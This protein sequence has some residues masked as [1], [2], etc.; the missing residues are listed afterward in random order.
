MTEPTREQ[1]IQGLRELADF[2]TANP[3]VPFTDH[4]FHQ[5]IETRE[6]WDALNETADMTSLKTDDWLVL[7]KLFTGGIRLDVNVERPR[8]ADDSVPDPSSHAY[9]SDPNW[10]D[11]CKVCGENESAH[12]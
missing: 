10:G 3:A 1:R 8:E 11:C 6:E 7:R 5:F 4:Q 2:L 9:V 12:Q